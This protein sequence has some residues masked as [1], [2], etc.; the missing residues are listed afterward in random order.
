M[1][2]SLFRILATVLTLGACLSPGGARAAEGSAEPVASSP[3]QVQELSGGA[4]LRVAPDTQYH[5]GRAVRLQIGPEGTGKT[6]THPIRLISGRLEIELPASDAPAPLTAVQVRGPNR[7][8]ALVKGGRA[9]VVTRGRKVS[10]AAV[11]GDLL[12]ATGDTW[13]NLA[14]GSVR[15][16]APGSP[17]RD[18]ALLATP[19]LALFSAV[20]L[21]FDEQKALGTAR[22]T[23]VNT[24]ASYDFEVW[25]AE[26]A[27]HALFR[28]WTMAESTLQVPALPTGSYAV[29]VRAVDSSGVPSRQSERLPLHVVGAELP[30]GAK[31]S[32]GEVLLSPEHRIRLS[33]PKNV[34]LGFGQAPD[35]FP[36]PDSVGLNRGKPALVRF[37]PVGSRAELALALEPQTLRAQIQIGPSRARWPNDEVT[38][39]IRVVDAR[40]RPVRA[41]TP[42][43]PL[44]HLNVTPVPLKW[45]RTRDLL[46]TV[47]PRPV[48]P[49]PYVVRVEIRDDQGMVFGRD[50]LEVAWD[51]PEARR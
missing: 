16:F 15:E 6:L 45:N 32:N 9:V 14:P 43:E 40:G 7:I 49:G 31:L 11:E 17:P 19:N 10:V 26:G 35:F 5:V 3:D 30:S 2:V 27:E 21:R 8:S 38:V 42:V 36:V 48:E 12:V 47:V 37:R 46:T 18:R 23:E 51:K 41:E 44:V 33:A 24:A 22:A 39:S 25:K 28:Q 50:F 13:R 29:A 1:E 4:S 20:A 34:E